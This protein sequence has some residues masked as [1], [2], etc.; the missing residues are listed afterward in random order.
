MKKIFS[1][2]LWAWLVIWV[3]YIGYDLFA[4]G[5]LQEYARLLPMTVEGRHAYV[6][7]G[8]LYEFISFADERLP[9]AAGYRLK[10]LAWDSLECRRTAYYLYP[11]L[12]SD[13]ADYL[14]IYDSPEAPDSRYDEF[15]RLDETRY[16]MKRRT[17]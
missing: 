9:P 5:R 15:A 14:L 7:G 13:D 6:T 4:K 2:M 17:P 11:H 1:V 16:I 12:G 8:R 10:G 3:F